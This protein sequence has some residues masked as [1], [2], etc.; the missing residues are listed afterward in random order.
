MQKLEYSREDNYN[1][2]LPVFIYSEKNQVGVIAGEMDRSIRKAT[3]VLTMHSITA[4]PEIP[5]GKTLSTKE[6]E[7]YNQSEFNK[8]VDDSY[9]LL[10]KAHFHKHEFQQAGE[11]F[12]FIVG[13]FPNGEP[14][15]EARIWLARLAIE[16]NR[17]K[18][19]E[20]LLTELANEPYLPKHLLTDLEST[21]AALEILRENFEAAANHLK[22]S[23]AEVRSKYYKQRHSFILA[24]LYQKN[25]QRRLA[26]QTYSKVV[27]LNPPY[28]MTFNARI[29]MALAYEK[30]TLQRREIEKQ[31]QKM[32]R[33]DK[34]IDFQ[35]QIYYAWG[36]LYIQ[37][38]NTD[39]A[40]AYY[41]KSASV[42][43]DNVFQQARTYLTIADIF[44][45]IPEYVPAQAYYDSAVGV[46]S[47]DY[48]NYDIIYAKSISLTNLVHGIQTI[49]LEDSVQ[50]LAYMPKEELNVF[51]DD[52]IESVRAYEE[53]ARIKEQ[54]MQLQAQMD[55]KQQFELTTNSKSWYFYNNTA[56]SL[57]RKEFK[58]K[59]GSRPL[60]DNWRRKNKSTVDA[61]AAFADDP[62]AEESEDGVPQ[63]VKTAS[64]YSREYYLA[65][66]P[67]T[68]SALELSHQRIMQ[69]LFS[70]GDIYTQELEDYD[71]ATSTYEE[72]LS[73]YPT[74][75]KR[76]L[77]YYKLYSIGKKTED[78]NR[79]SVYQQKIIKEF[80]E[81]NYALVLSDPD[82]FR[83]IE[84]QKRKEDIR[85]EQI[86]QVFEQGRYAQASEMINAALTEN[87]ES[88]YLMQYE[89]MRTIS[90]G[91]SKDTVIFISDLEKL[92]SRYPNTDIS[93]R[94]R[95][96]VEYL[97]SENPEAAREQAIKQAS[98]LYKQ[99]PEEEHFVVVAIASGNNPNQ[100][101]FNI[102]N[103]NID[104]FSEADLK[105]KKTEVAGMSLLN[106]TSFE[107][108]NEAAKYYNQIQSHTDLFHDV[109]K[110]DSLLFYISAS[111]K[112]LLER[113][114][115][116]EQYITFFNQNLK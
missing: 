73:R 101:M 98:E 15:F 79:V 39:E 78:I 13:N 20:N 69:A 96:L 53:E 94:S 100:L 68:D 19:A 109:N 55:T 10:G 90:E 43:K 34:N 86:Y 57:G 83:K 40:I 46:I 70:M 61:G 62:E 25:N 41:I 50:K 2:L 29:N 32:L 27:K 23:V 44:Y 56:V 75:E 116:L 111:N 22:K 66:I 11:T 3:K 17:A 87:P 99:N 65:D 91:A 81:S 112:R 88:K 51:I 47:S 8:W 38:G 74:Y 37:E 4:K 36:N 9:L 31:L 35:D 49:A 59:W 52:I 106:I 113:D 97:K 64:K 104:N 14:Q 28:E 103:F 85:Y 95:L 12:Q 63:T 77:V 16:K 84:E 1:E 108:Q 6:R 33:D 67:F 105:V 58:R 21:W 92:I 48:P 107:N 42:S 72:L 82:Y 71:K 5:A 45:E 7:F 93:D 76:L 102:I 114:M 110:A 89:Y 18:E 26:S 30:G 54:E 60:E 80:P 115:M 24:Q